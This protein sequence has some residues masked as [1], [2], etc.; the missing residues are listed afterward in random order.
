VGKLKKILKEEV[1]S[2]TGK[3]II[4]VDIQPEYEPAIHFSIP[5]W[6]EWL[7]QQS[8]NNKI[9]FLFNGT[10][11]VGGVSEQEYIS[12]LLNLCI[13]NDIDPDFINGSYFYDKGYAFFRYCMDSGIDDDELVALIRFMVANDI[14]DSR[15]IDSD[16]WKKF[17]KKY[18]EYPNLFKLLKDE[19]G[20]MINI[21]ELMDELRQ[22]NNIVIMGG[23]VDEC[24]KEVELALQSLDKSYITVPQFIF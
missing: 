17:E 4:N 18:P 11:T 3:T 16:N 19:M 6:L 15:D 2:F 7:E 1:K 14:N 22:Y 13:E 5:E 10:D 8:E 12:W 21:P 20:E 24:L 9:V 23:G